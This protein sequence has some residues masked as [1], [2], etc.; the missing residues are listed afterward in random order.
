MGAIT[1]RTLCLTLLKEQEEHPSSCYRVFKTLLYCFSVV[2]N[3]QS[4]VSESAHV[5]VPAAS[6]SAGN[7]HTQD[8]H[9]ECGPRPTVQSALSLQSGKY[10]SL[11]LTV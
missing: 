10:S 2:M 1:V 9:C 8:A 6:E 11:C 5:A 3:V 7:N 4:L